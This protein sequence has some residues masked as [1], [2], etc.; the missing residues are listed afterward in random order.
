VRTATVKVAALAL[1]CLS[2]VVLA[3][4]LTSYEKTCADIGFK[5]R[6]PAFGEC[7]LELDR[8]AKAQQTRPTQSR[9]AQ[10]V[11]ETVVRGDGTPDDQQCQGFGWNVGT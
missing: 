1:V 2:G 8:R 9:P 3:S 4:D 6:T 5:K 11:R 10:E 7:V